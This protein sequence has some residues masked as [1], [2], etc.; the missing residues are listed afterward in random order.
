MAGKRRRY[1]PE[2]K[3]EAVRLVTEEGL[4]V[5]QAANDL[6]ISQSVLSRWVAKA[7]QADREGTPMS[8]L[9]A[10]NRRLRRENELL[11]KEREILKKAAA[12][13]AKETL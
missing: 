3:T 10:E 11:K 12:F 4:S 13:F 6:G 7:Q 1:T 5:T 9:E 8:E 2:F